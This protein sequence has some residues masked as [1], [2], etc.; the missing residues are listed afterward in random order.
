MQYFVYILKSIK[1]GKRYI[2]MSSNLDRRI[3]EHNDGKVKSTKFRKPFELIYTEEF[4][5]KSDALK[6]EKFLKT[7]AGR[8]FL[9][10]IN[11]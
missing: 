5:N 10:S 6:R 1:D 8:N 7:H 3:S 9:D 4:N 2:G 11:K